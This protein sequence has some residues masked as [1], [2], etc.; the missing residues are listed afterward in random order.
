ME[1]GV[2]LLN[3]RNRAFVDY[4]SEEVYL[5]PVS[6]KSLIVQV[7]S[8]LVLCAFVVGYL[9][10][11][12]HDLGYK[13]KLDR[14][15][16]EGATTEGVVTNKWDGMARSGKAPIHK[17]TLAFRYYVNGLEHFG[18]QDVS[19]YSYNAYSIGDTVV[20]RYLTD[21]P[22]FAVLRI[23]YPDSGALGSSG[24]PAQ[25]IWWWTLGVVGVGVMAAG[26]YL[27]YRLIREVRQR[28]ALVLEGRLIFVPIT[29]CAISERFLWDPQ[30]HLAYELVSPVTG[31][32]LGG[33]YAGDWR[34]EPS[35]PT[36]GMVAAVLYKDDKHYQVL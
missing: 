5:P 14:L 11:L 22:S 26:G 33:R 21:E 34:V 28:R 30:I 2:F 10:S 1:R 18:A 7:T 27:A 29:G 19:I 32:W 20:V 12:N 35:C 36:Q 25:Q 9:Y 13:T 8:I 31:Q 17:Y 24:V 23:A 15:T 4:A 16:S 6:H 3:E